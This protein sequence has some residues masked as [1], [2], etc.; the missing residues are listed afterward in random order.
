VTNN[1]LLEVMVPVN[2]GS[3]YFRLHKP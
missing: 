3:R 1:G 2:P